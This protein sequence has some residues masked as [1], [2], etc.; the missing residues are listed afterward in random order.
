MNT[1]IKLM[2]ALAGNQRLPH[3][4]ADIFADFELTCCY[5]NTLCKDEDWLEEVD[6]NYRSAR[7]AYCYSVHILDARWSEAE[8]IISGIPWIAMHYAV[9]V[10]KGRWPEGE[11]AIASNATYW[12]KYNDFLSELTK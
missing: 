1:D 10:I 3:L 4:E 11:S 2:I 8:P 9:D 5:L 7:A 12:K 6:T